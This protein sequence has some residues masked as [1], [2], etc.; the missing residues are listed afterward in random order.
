MN[1][2]RMS[3]VFAVI[4]LSGGAATSLAGPGWSDDFEDD[5]IDPSLWVVGG[6]N[7]GQSSSDPGSWTWSHDETVF[8]DGDPDGYMRARVQGPTSGLSYGA[9]AWVRTTYDFNDGSDY[10]LNFTWKAD[11]SDP[12][13]ASYHIQVTDGYMATLEEFSGT[14]WAPVSPALSG[15][16]AT[17]G[18]LYSDAQHPLN[19]KLYPSDSEKQTWSMT[20]SASAVAR[21][22]DGPD[23]TGSL[24][25]EGSLDPAEPWYVRFML[26][27]ATSAG[28]PAGDSRLN[29]HAIEA[30]PEPATLALLAIGGLSA[31]RRRR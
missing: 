12:H 18:L 23:A 17:V 14:P 6:R 27:D 11:V 29:L 7:I 22:Y 8:D 31:I 21:L 1:K 4:I 3:M 15:F 19:G 24:L 28:F 10:T 26:D 30:T 5:L 20:I 13:H 25:G 9:I 16:D 2:R